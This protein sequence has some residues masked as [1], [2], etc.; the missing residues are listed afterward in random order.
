MRWRLGLIDSCGEQAGSV[1]S[2]C[3]MADG[4]KVRRVLSGADPTGHGSRIAAILTHN[5]SNCDLLLAQVF[6]TP[7]PTCAAVVSAA[8]DWCLGEG[9]NLMHIS[10]H[11]TVNRPVLAA[12]VA[13][14]VAQDCIVMAATPARGGVVY[15]AAYSGVIRGTGDARCSPS[16]ISR[17][18]PATFGGCPRHGESTVSDQGASIGAAHVTRKLLEGVVQRTS[19]EASVALTVR[20]KYWGPERSVSL[21]YEQSRR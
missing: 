12:A 17:L 3:F 4:G 8:I 6:A 11:L 18:A 1:A 15:P 20:A 14:A 9:V 7:G 2:A 19:V 5:L 13:R 21:P 10:L 16:E